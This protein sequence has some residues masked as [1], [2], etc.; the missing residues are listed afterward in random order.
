MIVALVVGLN[1]RV[2]RVL[3]PY[4]CQKLFDGQPGAG[5]ESAQGTSGNLGMVW[6]REGCRM[7]GLGENDVAAALPS[8]FPSELVESRH[9]V[10][11]PKQ[12]NG[13]HQ[14]TTSTS[15]VVTVSGICFSARTARHSW[16]A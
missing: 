14:L 2:P 15:R 5:D 3:R 4:G 7:S 8:H 11:R 9:D 10:P 1:A 12:R 6:N 16:M 13:R